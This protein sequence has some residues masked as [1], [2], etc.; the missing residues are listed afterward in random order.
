M[1]IIAMPKSAS[2]SLART[3]ARANGLDERNDEINADS[4]PQFINQHQLAQELH[5]FPHVE[6][7][8]LRAIITDRAT[9]R[10]LHLFPTN[11][12]LKALE[13]GPAVVLLRDPTEVIDAEF[14]AVVNG[15][16]PLA[17]SMPRTAS[18]ERW[19]RAAREGGLLSSLTAL[20]ES[21]IDAA[22]R[23]E[24]LLLVSYD[25]LMSHPMETL[26]A[27]AA[28]LGLSESGN[29]LLRERWSGIGGSSPTSRDRVGVLRSSMY[30]IGALARR[31]ARA[32]VRRVAPGPTP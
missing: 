25:D 22:D 6:V 10:K 30:V 18:I 15:I 8:E 16:H 27:C 12:V 26:A 5:P 14:R 24:G 21:W 23:M 2:S 32:V 31:V 19:R 28:H 1:L 29:S 17:P 11:D 13:A 3:L 9:L 7:D 20:H 4:P